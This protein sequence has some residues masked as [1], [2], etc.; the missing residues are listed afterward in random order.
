[1]EKSGFVGVNCNRCG[2]TLEVDE[3]TRFVTCNYCHSRLAIQRTDSAVFT[4]VLANLEAQTGKI[5][6]SLKVMTLQKDLEQLDREWDQSRASLMVSGRGG[7]SDPSYIVGVFA[8][9]VGVLFGGFWISM[10]IKD[11]APVF[12][13]IFGV[14]FMAAA[15]IGGVTAMA[16]AR[17]M[18]D[19]RVEYDQRRAELLKAIEAEKR[20]H[21]ASK[22]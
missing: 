15:V 14:V 3:H 16:K 7:R 5:A 19:R 2:A 6:E 10:T 22:S 13:P 4:E 8:M 21:S 20:G 9:V 11:G 17:Q 12:F 18:S 1:M